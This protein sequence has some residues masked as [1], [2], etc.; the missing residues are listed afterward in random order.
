MNNQRF[1]DAKTLTQ[2]ID[3]KVDWLTERLQE[4]PDYIAIVRQYIPKKIHHLDALLQ[5]MSHGEFALDQL[6][7]SDRYQA[8]QSTLE[9]TTQHIQQLQ[10]ENVGEVLQKLVDD[11][12]ALMKD[13]EVEK[14]SYEVF[15]NKWEDAYT[16]I[17]QIYDQY[18]QALIDQNR[19]ENLYLINEDYVDI[20]EKYKDFDQIL[21][22]SYELEEEM[23]AGN[24]SYLQ[25]IDKVEKVKND[26]LSHQDDLDAFFAFRDH[27]YLQEQ[28]AIDELENINIVLL[29]IKSEIKNKH[30]PM[31]NES[32]K[33]YIQDSYDKQHRYR[34]IVCIVL[35]NYQNFLSE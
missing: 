20:Q 23:N 15:K 4:L 22:T 34:L 12:D 11:I 30:L 14:Q 28:R 5:D 10:L 17:T 29:E 9:T 21:R 3:K 7:V 25:M 1:E 19:I 16:K 13:L 24:F 6:H 26:A 32:Y 27:L 2:D 33:D 31:I 18:K 35:L 8:I